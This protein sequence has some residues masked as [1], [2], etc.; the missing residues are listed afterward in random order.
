VVNFPALIQAFSMDLHLNIILHAL[1]EAFPYVIFFFRNVTNNAQNKILK[2]KKKDP[3]K[4]R[5]EILIEDLPPIQDLQISVPAEECMELGKISNIVD[6]L[7]MCEL[8]LIF[9]HQTSAG[10]WF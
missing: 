3:M 7:G 9:I 1:Y 8:E 6:Q 4:T 2:P 10:L 5:G